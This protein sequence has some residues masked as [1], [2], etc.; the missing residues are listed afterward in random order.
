MEIYVCVWFLTIFH[1]GPHRSGLVLRMQ[2]K[3]HLTGYQSH[4]QKDMKDWKYPPRASQG[5]VT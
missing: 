2:K 5:I 3:K 1:D 4:S